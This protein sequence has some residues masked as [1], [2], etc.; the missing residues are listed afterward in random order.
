MEVDHFMERA[1]ADR[2]MAGGV[3]MVS[4]G[5]KIGLYR[6]YGEMDLEAHKPMQ[7]LQTSS[8]I[9][10]EVSWLPEGSFCAPRQVQRR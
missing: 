6:A 1:V 8:N 10:T 2:K 5:G 4:H 9:T 7:A 3:V